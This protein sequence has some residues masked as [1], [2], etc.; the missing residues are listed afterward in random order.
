MGIKTIKYCPTRSHANVFK[1]L[2]SLKRT[3]VSK[4]W[5]S[6]GMQRSS[7][8][9]PYRV[10]RILGTFVIVWAMGSGHVPF[11]TLC[12]MLNQ[13][14]AVRN[15]IYLVTSLQSVLICADSHS[16]VVFAFLAMMASPMKRFFFAF[17]QWLILLPVSS[18]MI[19]GFTTVVQ[20][21]RVNCFYEK[22]DTN[23]SLEI[24]YQ[25]RMS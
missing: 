3:F 15:R 2:R 10:Q 12:R 7:R 16:L 19:N 13:P 9:R 8:S 22:I 6:L 18:A 14:Q 24:E 23:K 21:G 1:R 17:L 25:V 4:A 5:G 20:A 11:W